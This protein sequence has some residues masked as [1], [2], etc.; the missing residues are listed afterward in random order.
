MRRLAFVL[1]VLVL[2]FFFSPQILT[3]LGNFLVQTEIPAKADAVVI[4]AGDW[5]GERVLKGAELVKQGYAP[6][7]YM[8]GPNLVY[9]VNEA[10]L[11]IAYGVA[12]GYPARYFEAMRT[13]ALSTRDEADYFYREL[14]RRGIHKVLLVTSNFH[15]HRA[16][17][18]FRGRFGSSIEVHPVA[19]PSPYF[20]P[21]RWWKDREG[22][23]TFFFEWS[24]MIA[25]PLGL[26][27]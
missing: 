18:I 3:A 8:S 5:T 12:Q 11:A 27:L 14:S 20:D 16:A 25:T 2:L 6:I 24:K 9:G 4:L 1:V 21:G 17:I 10:D 26:L 15:T 23:K 22:R 13:N 19:A 7:A